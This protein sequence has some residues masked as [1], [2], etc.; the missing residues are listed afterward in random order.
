M[1]RDAPARGFLSCT[2]ESE[3]L[4]LAISVRRWIPSE[5]VLTVAAIPA[6]ALLLGL[7]FWSVRETDPMWAIISFVLVYDTDAR[8]AAAAG[9]SRLGLTILGSAFAMAAVFG[10]GLHK[11]TLPVSLGLSAILCAGFLRSRAGWRI[12]L[13]TVALIV[14]SSLLQPEI[15]PYIAVTRSIEVACGS[16][17]AIAFS[18]LAARW[19]GEGTTSSARP[20]T[21]V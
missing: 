20:G 18:W 11:W 15:A 4:S 6:G 13:V 7:L 21:P 1:P 17:L 14:G 5:T 2:D 3:P 16:T 12:V 9:W 8:S 19:S 10:L